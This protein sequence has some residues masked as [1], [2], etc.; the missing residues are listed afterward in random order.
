[1]AWV[2]LSLRRGEIAGARRVLRR[3]DA[4]MLADLVGVAR[5]DHPEI[6]PPS[7]CLL[8]LGRKTALPQ[9]EKGRA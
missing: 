9:T 5:A 7:I 3:A 2:A 8:V 6:L 1:M 4:D